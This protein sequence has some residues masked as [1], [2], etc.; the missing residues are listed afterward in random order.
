MIHEVRISCGL[1]EFRAHSETA[2]M[3]DP[4]LKL[5]S[6]VRIK[7]SHGSVFVPY[8]LIAVKENLLFHEN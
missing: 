8:G 6:F 4:V 3:A 7:D 2:S 1:W 5:N